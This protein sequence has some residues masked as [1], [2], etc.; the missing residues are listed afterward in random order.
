MHMAM[1]C[2]SCKTFLCNTATVSE[3]ERCSSVPSQG[4]STLGVHQGPSMCCQGHS[5]QLLM[6][7]SKMQQLTQNSCFR[8]AGHSP[9]GQG[10]AI[11][12]AIPETLYF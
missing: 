3:K 8:G 12:A 7:S 5:S 10:K 6:G 2:Y 4:C 11:P 1:L 9:E